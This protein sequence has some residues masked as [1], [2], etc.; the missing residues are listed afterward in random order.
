MGEFSDE[1]AGESIRSRR[2]RGTLRSEA[3]REVLRKRAERAAEAP[4]ENDEAPWEVQAMEFFNGRL[5]EINSKLDML[6]EKYIG[7]R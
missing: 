1:F 2:A 3:T 7:G 4:S 6:V 5:D